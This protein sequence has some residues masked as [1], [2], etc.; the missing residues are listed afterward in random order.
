LVKKVGKVTFINP[1]SVGRPYDGDWRAS[2]AILTAVKGEISV[3]HR[4]IE[5]DVDAAV[6]AVLDAGYP[7]DYSWALKIG[8]PPDK[9]KEMQN[10]SK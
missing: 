7:E 10:K 4:K 5:Y 9:V 2:Y 6:T 1:G 8:L 3:E